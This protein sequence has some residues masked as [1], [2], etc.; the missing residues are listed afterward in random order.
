MFL[1]TKQHIIHLHVSQEFYRTYL[2]L[3]VNQLL[4][5]VLAL[6]F[7]KFT[8]FMTMF[9][10]VVALNLFVTVWARYWLEVAFTFMTL[11]V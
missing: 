5:T 7:S 10:H 6:V 1:R 9:L 2:H 8:F 3:V 4:A 11:C